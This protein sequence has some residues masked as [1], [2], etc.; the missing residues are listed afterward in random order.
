MLYGR[1][2]NSSRSF[3]SEIIKRGASDGKVYAQNRQWRPFEFRL[4]VH[5]ASMQLLLAARRGAGERRF[6]SLS[7]SRRL[8]ESFR[9]W[10]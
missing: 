8:L 9:A 3:R 4:P 7:L 10:E 1:R 6:Q 2:I 5:R